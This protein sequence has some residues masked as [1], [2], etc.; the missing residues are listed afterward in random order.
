MF[1]LLACAQLSFNTQLTLE[2]RASYQPINGCAQRF[3]V[4]QHTTHLDMVGSKSNT[5]SCHSHSKTPVWE[6]MKRYSR[7]FL[8]MFPLLACAQLSFKAQGKN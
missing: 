2:K 4:T 8:Y 3:E 7:M 1:P 5:R 6:V